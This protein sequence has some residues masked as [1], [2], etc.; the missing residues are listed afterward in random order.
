MQ[1]PTEQR[2]QQ[3]PPA[4]SSSSPSTSTPSRLKDESIHIK[5]D[6]CFNDTPDFR[7]RVTKSEQ[8]LLGLEGTIKQLLKLTYQSIEL[9]SGVYL[10][11]LGFL[12]IE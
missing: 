2:Q 1:S 4:A 11:D 9:Q 5:L 12:F 7:A 8:T 10:F 3:Q 6:D